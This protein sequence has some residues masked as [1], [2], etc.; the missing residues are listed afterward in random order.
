MVCTNLYFHVFINWN[1]N[2]TSNQLTVT[3]ERYFVN[4]CFRKLIMMGF[5]WILCFSGEATLHLNGTVK[6]HICRNRLVSHLMKVSNIW[7]TRQNLMCGVAP[8]KLFSLSGSDCGKTAIS[9]CVR[10]IHSRMKRHH[11]SETLSVSFYVN[12]FRPRGLEAAVSDHAP[13]DHQT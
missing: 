12:T 1:F 2:S 7:G 4:K 5:S 10:T 6:R 9:R 3:V 8:L 13:W 11:T